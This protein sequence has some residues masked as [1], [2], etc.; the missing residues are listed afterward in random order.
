MTTKP[1]RMLG[2]VDCRGLAEVEAESVAFLVCSHRRSLDRRLLLPLRRALGAVAIRRSLRS[3]ADR[4]LGAAR[5]LTASLGLTERPNDAATEA[6]LAPR[7]AEPRTPEPT[8]NT[9]DGAHARPRPRAMM[10]PSRNIGTNRPSPGFGGEVL[11]LGLA[12]LLLW[13]SFCLLPRG[14]TRRAR[15]AR[16]FRDRAMRRRR[17]A[18]DRD[19][20]P[21][22]VT[23]HS[24]GPPRHVGSSPVACSSTRSPS[25]SSPDRSRSALSVLMRRRRTRAVTPGSRRRPRS[26]GVSRP[27][28]C[29]RTHRRC[30]RR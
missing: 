4:S 11:L 9:A 6:V 24:P 8:P 19:R 23:R 14:R 10:S 29:A 15:A 22:R 27:K 18:R 5:K 26:D 3:T 21:S 7:P 25:S 2:G 13:P 17:H 16:A 28:P 20:S 30:G 1:F 12:I